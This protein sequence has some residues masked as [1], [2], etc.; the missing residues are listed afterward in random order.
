MTTTRRLIQAHIV[1]LLLAAAL[2]AAI[3]PAGAQA[4][5]DREEQDASTTD[6]FQVVS[7]KALD[8]KTVDVTFNHGLAV[9]TTDVSRKHFHGD[10]LDH[11]VPHTHDVSAVALIN[12]GKTA[13]LTFSRALHPEEAPCDDPLP[14]CSDDEIPLII[15]NVAD[16]YAN[17]VNNSDWEIWDTGA[18]N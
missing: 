15:K 9:E 4:S 17:V 14:K 2:A 13:R 6:G 12:E 1:V 5:D 11:E 7:V 3:F 16:V 18:K 8:A 10:H